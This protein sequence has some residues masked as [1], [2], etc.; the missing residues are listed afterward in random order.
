MKKVNIG[1]FLFAILLAACTPPSGTQTSTDLVAKGGKQ[2]GGKFRFNERTA[3]QTLFPYQISDEVSFRI[4][5]QVYEGLVKFSSKD[6][7]IMPAIA[8][9]WEVNEEGTVYTFHLK[10][11]VMFTGV[12]SRRVFLLHFQR[13]VLINEFN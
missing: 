3:L 2:Y 1:I 7:S 4:G 13:E 11:G 5:T 8:E 9:S 12:L 6:L 10:K